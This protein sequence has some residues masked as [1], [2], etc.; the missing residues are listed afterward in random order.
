[1]GALGL[2]ANSV[3]YL[4]LTTYVVTLGK[5]LTLAKPYLIYDLV[6]VVDLKSKQKGLYCL[7]DE[8]RY[9]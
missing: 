5:S 2:N 9:D 4:S 7:I 8:M 1:M 6:S 3:S